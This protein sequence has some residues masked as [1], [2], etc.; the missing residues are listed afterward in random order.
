MREYF[1][2]ETSTGLGATMF[3]YARPVG[4][5][6]TTRGV[7]PVLLASK[8]AMVEREGNIR[9][10][11]P[12]IPISLVYRNRNTSTIIVLIGDSDFVTNVIVQFSDKLRFSNALYMLNLVEFLTEQQFNIRIP[13][14]ILVE[15]RLKRDKSGAIL[16][17][18][19][20]F[21]RLMTMSLV[22]QPLI[23]LLIAF[24]IFR[25]YRRR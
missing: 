1:Q 22:G 17:S 13:P 24:F 16:M 4:Y 12:N 25:R 18:Q 6:N 21:E 23:V 14:R 7:L 9:I 15:S 3:P 20:D 10:R 19:R 2:H 8:H 11:A 5:R